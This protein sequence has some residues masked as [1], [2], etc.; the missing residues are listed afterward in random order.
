VSTMTLQELTAE[1]APQ[2]QKAEPEKPEPESEAM[3]CL[4]KML[5]DGMGVA[6]KTPGGS[7]ITVF[8]YTI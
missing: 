8:A 2:S 3:R 7:V 4:K 6:F 5:L 1:I